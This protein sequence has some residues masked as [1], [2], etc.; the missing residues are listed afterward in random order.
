[1]GNQLVSWISTPLFLLSCS[2]RTGADSDSTKLIPMI[3]TVTTALI[4][5]PHTEVDLQSCPNRFENWNF[6]LKIK[7]TANL[8]AS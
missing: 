1:M 2:V 5:Y 7:T 8:C 3:R 4:I 6:K